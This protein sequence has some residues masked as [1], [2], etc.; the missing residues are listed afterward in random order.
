ML[1]YLVVN[2]LLVL[3]LGLVARSVGNSMA[4]GGGWNFNYSTRDI[5]I[6]AVIAALAGVI[7][8]G[9]GNVWFAAN[10]SLGPLGGALLQ[11]AFMWAYILVAWLIRK[12][13]AALI[14]GVIETAVEVLLGNASGVGTIG[15]GVTQG[16]AVEVVLAFTAYNKYDLVTAIAAGAASSQFGTLWTAILFGWDP[17]FARDVWLA[18][19]VNLISGAIIS[20]LIGFYLSRAIARTGLV[21]A[22]A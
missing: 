11:G 14:L 10:A 22:A 20:G 2:V 3:V 19:P 18:V 4:N 5:V 6:I 13:G 17:A 7:N 16:L 12:P 1:V 8:T 15:W 9:T 21:R